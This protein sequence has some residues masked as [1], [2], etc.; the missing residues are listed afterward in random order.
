MIYN[1]LQSRVKVLQPSAFDAGVYLNRP[2]SSQFFSA[3]RLRK[4]NPVMGRTHAD[5]PTNQSD[6]EILDLKNH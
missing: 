3:F 2:F 1:T 4:F 6:F 5:S